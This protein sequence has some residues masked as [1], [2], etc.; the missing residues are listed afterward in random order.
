[1]HTGSQQQYN[2][3]F[4]QRTLHDRNDR[5]ERRRG[6]RKPAGRLSRSDVHVRRYIGIMF[7][8]RSRGQGV[9]SATCQEVTVYYVSAYICIH[10]RRVLI[11][12]TLLYGKD[13][14]L[15]DRELQQQRRQKKTFVRLNDPTPHVCGCVH[16]CVC[17][18]ISTS[19]RLI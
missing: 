11:M 19:E 8:L 2:N 15:I 13:G 14:R 7:D 6:G 9:T 17:S 3:V 10:T 4:I 16:A 18:H 1:M 12:R 5:T